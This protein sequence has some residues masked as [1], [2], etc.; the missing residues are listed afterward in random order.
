[1]A[2]QEHLKILLSGVDN[3]NKWRINNKIIIPDLS[4]VDLSDTDF[5]GSDLSETKFFGTTLFRANLSGTN[6][7]ETDLRFTDL[8]EANFSR[9]NL[10][11]ADLRGANLIS[12]IFSN[13]ILTGCK[14]YGVSVW[15]VDTTNSIQNGLIITRHDQSVI[16]VDNIK[17]AHFAYLLL[18]NKEIRDVINTMT[19]KS[20][21]LLG[22]FGERKKILDAMAEW[23]RRNN[24]LPIIMDFEQPDSKDFTETVRT[25]AGLSKYVIVD[26]T[27]PKSVQQEIAH[28][29][30]FIEMPIIP[31][32]EKGNREYS[33]FKDMNKYHWV[34]PV[35]EYENENELI[36]I[37]QK[38]VI[39]PAEDK[40][41]EI[42]LRK[43]VKTTDSTY[44]S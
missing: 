32:I 26:L 19:G 27:S 18:N 35:V 12:T 30:P 41:K 34:L 1:M 25:L 38:R 39:G 24:L 17:V 10:S 13:A 7:R 31:L 33:M 22:R 42:T 28:I 16:T 43:K 20:V 14:I 36:D 6:L 21:L 2:N 8:S 40:Y 3:W 9:A 5:S 29:A 15:D 4:R 37:M 23:L 11:G 44:L